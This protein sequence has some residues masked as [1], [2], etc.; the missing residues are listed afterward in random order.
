[1]DRECN[2]HFALSG[3]YMI[4]HRGVSDSSVVAEAKGPLKPNRVPEY[5]FECRTEP[6]S[7]HYIDFMT[8]NTPPPRFDISR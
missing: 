2:V 4:Q 7:S 8:L 5:R 6:P 1:M 3:V